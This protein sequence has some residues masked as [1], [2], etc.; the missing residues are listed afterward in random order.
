MVSAF[1]ASGAE[2]YLSF[3]GLGLDKWFHI[4][5]TITLFGGKFQIAWYG[6]LITLGMVLAF[7]Y[8]LYRARK[9]GI[10]TDDV[11]D[12]ALFTITSTCAICSGV[13]AS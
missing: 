13:I 5:K 12:I 8:A 9:I 11:L 10:K 1:A 3:P 2:E 6:I 7:S 4:D